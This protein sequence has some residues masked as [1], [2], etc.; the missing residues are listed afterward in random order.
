VKFNF[1]D[2]RKKFRIRLSPAWAGL[3]E[4]RIANFASENCLS[5]LRS[6]C[7]LFEVFA[8]FP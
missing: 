5:E 7:T 3:G 8:E 4:F 2:K 1:S 6:F